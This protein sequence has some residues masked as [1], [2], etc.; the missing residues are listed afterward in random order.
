[1]F[2]RCKK[3]KKENKIKRSCDFILFF[4]DILFLHLQH[5]KKHWDRNYGYPIFWKKIIN[6]GTEEI[7]L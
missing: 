1:M 3:K 7:K 6:L 5:I 4:K 2:K